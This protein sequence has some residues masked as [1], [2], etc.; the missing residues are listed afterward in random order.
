M[1]TSGAAL[2]ADITV[3]GV[4]LSREELY[5]VLRLLKAK[6]IP[7]F[8]TSWARVDARGEP[9]PETAAAVRAGMDALV[10]RGWVQLLPTQ[11][12][13]AQQ[14]V[15]LPAP[16]VALVGACAFSAFT[17][18]FVGIDDGAL[19]VFYFHQFGALGSLHSTPQPDIHLFMPLNG[20]QG[21]LKG[22]ATMVGVGDTPAVGDQLGIIPLAALRDATRAARNR[23]GEGVRRALSQAATPADATRAQ[24]AQA[25]SSQPVWG[26]LSVGTRDARGDTVERDLFTL[27]ATGVAFLFAPQPHDPAL[28]GIYLA[29]AHRIGDWVGAQLPA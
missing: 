6:D 28:L 1:T 17:V 14:R 22:I 7:G 5:V 4:T 12:P 26:E 11:T 9:T 3:P 13:G 19:R 25:L 24:L 18:R 21:V 8:D 2:S 29:N 15:E 23:D 20:R 16:V 10:A 27:A